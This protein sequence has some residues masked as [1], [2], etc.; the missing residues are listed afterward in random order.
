MSESIAGLAASALTIRILCGER[1]FSSSLQDRLSPARSWRWRTENDSSFRPAQVL[2][3][4]VDPK[5]QVKFE[6]LNGIQ[7]SSISVLFL[8]LSIAGSSDSSGVVV[9]RNPILRVLD[10]RDVHEDSLLTVR[11]PEVLIQASRTRPNLD[12]QRS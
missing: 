9:D 12:N 8:L 11:A 7:N 5:G 4:V 10:I 1:R 6:Y 3:G 2:R